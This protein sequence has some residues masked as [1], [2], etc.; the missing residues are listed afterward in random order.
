VGGNVSIR[1]FL[2]PRPDSLPVG[3]VDS[4]NNVLWFTDIFYNRIGNAMIPGQESDLRVDKNNP[5]MLFFGHTR[6]FPR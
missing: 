2:I 4:S 6:R 3:I 1:E 5:D